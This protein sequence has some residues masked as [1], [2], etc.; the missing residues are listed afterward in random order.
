MRKYITILLVIALLATSLPAAAGNIEFKSNIDD[1]DFNNSG[2]SNFNISSDTIIKGAAVIA[3]TGG[4]IYLGRYLYK[5]S[6]AHDLYQEARVHSQRDNWGIA[7]E[8]Y[9]E[10]INI[11]SN[12]KD[13]REKLANARKMAE[14]KFIKLGDQARAKEKYE[15]AIDYYHKAKRYRPDSFKAQNRLDEITEKM[16]A[17]HY[18]RGHSYEIQQN[19]NEAYR[20]YRKAYNINQ[21]YKDLASRYFRA[22][23]HIKGNIAL[24]SLVFIINRTEMQGLESP[25]INEFQKSLESVIS[26][27]FY[28]MKEKNW[29]KL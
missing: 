14:A 7:V 20:E 28:M 22:R 23:A 11:I 8:K 18:R 17:V 5:R 29:K 24:R 19:W 16:V 21:D 25:F 2:N 4:V 13:T 12:Y 10:T 3:I 26:D 6:K 1:L 9:E 27:N 15:K